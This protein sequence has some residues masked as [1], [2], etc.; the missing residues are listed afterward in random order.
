M[1]AARFPCL[2][3]RSGPFHMGKP[4]ATRQSRKFVQRLHRQVTKVAMQAPFGS[5]PGL[6]PVIP[7]IGQRVLP[8]GSLLRVLALAA[9][10]TVGSSRYTLTTSVKGSLFR[11]SRGPRQTSA[12]S[13]RIMAWACR[14]C[15][16]GILTL[17]RVDGLVWHPNLFCFSKQKKPYIQ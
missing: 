11:P 16:C 8:C 14:L 3:I 1:E 10:P 5:A 17:N 9:H 4:R 12:G 6:I 13:F 15:L 7:S 2:L